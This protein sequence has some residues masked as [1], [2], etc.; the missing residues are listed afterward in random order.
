MSD[1]FDIHKLPDRDKTKDYAK[2]YTQSPSVDNQ[3]AENEHFDPNT[4]FQPYETAQNS[5]DGGKDIKIKQKMNAN[6]NTSAMLE[7]LKKNIKKDVDHRIFVNKVNKKK[8]TLR[9]LAF[10]MWD[11]LE[12]FGFDLKKIPR[13]YGKDIKWYDK[14]TDMESTP[15]LLLMLILFIYIAATEVDKILHAHV[16]AQTI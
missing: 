14:F 2:I 16:K 13:L 6:L 4:V 8:E 11:G 1:Y 5:M 10:I 3:T 15:I 9:G 12:F 7:G